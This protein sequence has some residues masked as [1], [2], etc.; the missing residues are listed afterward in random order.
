MDGGGRPVTRLTPY[1]IAAVVVCI[2]VAVP[3]N[4]AAQSAGSARGWAGASFGLQSAPAGFD[5]IETFSA[6]AETGTV[7]SRYAT[8]AGRSLNIGGG[9][10]LLPRLGVGVA[11]SHTT[12]S[13]PAT[14][15][16]MVPH[17][18]FFNQPRR[19]S[20]S[21][22]D[23]ERTESV[24]HLQARIQLP[25]SSRFELAVFGGPSR[26]QVTQ[27]LVSEARFTDSYP[28]DEVSLASS[29]ERVNGSGLGVHAGGDVAFYPSAHMGIGFMVQVSSA[30]VTV[31]TT[32]VK[33]GG[34]Q[35]GGGLRLRF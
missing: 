26:F 2:A 33:A 27:G 32:E 3:N 11:F 8:S 12:S 28:Y 1:L 6:N 5:T 21:F 14:L 9:A 20:A 10:F 4:A 24:L 22:D 31:G 23:L 17:P 16:A 34:A 18:F 25:L 13:T 7:E 29:A 35:F 15:T 19:V 30:T